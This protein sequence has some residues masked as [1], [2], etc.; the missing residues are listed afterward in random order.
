[1][2]RRTSSAAIK[3][4]ELADSGILGLGANGWASHSDPVV[5]GVERA[6]VL[7]RPPSAI[8][9]ATGFRAMR[10]FPRYEESCELDSRES[11]L[12]E[13]AAGA[14][15]SNCAF[16]SSVEKTGSGESRFSGMYMLNSRGL[17]VAPLLWK[18]STLR[19][20]DGPLIEGRG[21]VPGLL[22]IRK[23]PRLDARDARDARLLLRAR[24]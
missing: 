24:H 18:L 22:L 11:R 2:G 19:K 13:R 20:S 1:M 14:G 3:S 4:C 17:K 12:C 10:K 9:G 16:K 8:D 7:R 5:D 21:A 23:L 6:S 15:Y